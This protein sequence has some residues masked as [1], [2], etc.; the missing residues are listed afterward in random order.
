MSK[1]IVKEKLWFCG[2]FIVDL[3]VF[4]CEVGGREVV[5]IEIP[6]FSLKYCT[7]I[8]HL[9]KYNNNNK[10]WWCHDTTIY[11]P[12][13]F[14]HVLCVI[15]FVSGFREKQARKK[16]FNNK[17]CTEQKK[18]VFDT[19]QKGLYILQNIILFKLVVCESWVG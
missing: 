8:F 19:N 12:K 17:K 10:W 11:Y 18:I 1:M 5:I 4:L 3:C 15:V 16:L 13:R 6:W 14:I 2:K 9:S 7:E